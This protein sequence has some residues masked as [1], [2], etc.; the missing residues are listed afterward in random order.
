MVNTF[1]APGRTIV[2]REMLD[3]RAWLVYPV[4]V[5]AHDADGLAVFTA[6]GTPLTFGQGEFS[7][8]PHP[9]RDI[10]DTWL[11]PGVLQLVRPGD[12]Y[13]V[14]S[15]P[16]GGWYVNFQ[17]PM[18]LTADGFD[19]LDQE[20]DL[21]IPPTPGTPPYTWKDED[22]FAHRAATGGFAPGEAESVRATAD[23]VAALVE[24]GDCWWDKWRDWRAPEHWTAPD[25]VPLP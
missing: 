11:S 23:R 17:R 24:S 3:G 20:L 14:W 13:S 16:T 5:V 25:R 7:L 15:R 9:W 1:F 21:L 22:E 18:R 4:R 2:R 6:Q 8:G 19:T 10:G 12:G